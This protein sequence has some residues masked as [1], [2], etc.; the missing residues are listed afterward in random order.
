V[1]ALQAE[2]QVLLAMHCRQRLPF[3]EEEAAKVPQLQGTI[4]M[5][6]VRPMRELLTVCVQPTLYRRGELT[7]RTFA[8]G[9][10]GWWLDRAISA[11][12]HL[13]LF[14][15]VA[16]AVLIL[17]PPYLRIDSRELSVSLALLLHSWK[18]ACA[19]QARRSRST[20]AGLQARRRRW[21]VPGRSC[22][23]CDRS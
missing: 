12:T 16:F 11:L 10:V 19:L 23:T 14:K 17:F 6:S 1:S 5:V 8:Y 18:P 7:C 22:K 15:A 21:R 20:L 9:L 4:H 2:R 13:S 3:L